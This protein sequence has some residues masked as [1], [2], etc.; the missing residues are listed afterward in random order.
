MIHKLVF[1]QARN[2]LLLS[3][4]CIIATFVVNELIEVARLSLHRYSLIAQ[5]YNQALVHLYASIAGNVQLFQTKTDIP[6]RSNNT[7]I[8]FAFLHAACDRTQN[9]KS[10]CPVEHETEKVV[11]M[12]FGKHCLIKI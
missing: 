6:A 11:I 3:L 7:L 10:V 9:L 8:A 4:L 2:Y 5:R 12:A 1:E